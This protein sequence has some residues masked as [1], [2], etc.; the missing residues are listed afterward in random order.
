MVSSKDDV[1]DSW[2][3]PDTAD[4]TTDR[5]G[6]A[7][8][9]GD[10]GYNQTERLFKFYEGGQK[11]RINVYSPDMFQADPTGAT[12]NVVELQAWLDAGAANNVP[13]MIPMG[14]AY[15][16]E[17]RI[18]LNDGQ[19]IFGEGETSKILRTTRNNAEASDDTNHAGIF[20]Q[21]VSNLRLDN[22]SVE[23]NGGDGASQYLAKAGVQTYTHPHNVG[24]EP[25]VYNGPSDEIGNFT[26][27][28]G[29]NTV[30]L[31]NAVSVNVLTVN[32]ITTGTDTIEFTA[33]HDMGFGE[34]VAFESTGTLPGGVADDETIYFFVPTS[35]TEGQVYA[36]LEDILWGSPVD[37]TT[38]GTGT[39][40]VR[41][42]DVITIANGVR[43]VAGTGWT[44]EHSAVLLDGCSGSISNM[45]ISGLYYQGLQCFRCS[46]LRIDNIEFNGQ[47]NRSLYIYHN[48]T[49]V[50]VN[51]VNIDC[52]DINTQKNVCAYGTIIA[53]TSG[54]QM[55]S[56]NVSNVNIRGNLTQ[57]F[58]VD[59]D[60]WGVNISNLNIFDGGA[61][62]FYIQTT[63]NGT[64]RFVN[65][66]NLNVLFTNPNQGIAVYT[67][68]CE[69]CS[70]SN[71]KI[72]GS[73]EGLRSEDFLG[74]E[75]RR[76]SYS[77]IHATKCRSYSIN[78][79]GNED[80]EFVNLYADGENLT[81][82]IVIF[83]TGGSQNT[84]TGITGKNGGNTHCVR[85]SSEIDLSASNINSIAG[86]C[87]HALYCDGC[88]GSISG[89]QV[90]GGTSYALRV[91]SEG[92]GK[93]LVSGLLPNNG[94]FSNVRCDAATTANT[95][96]LVE[97]GAS[98]SNA[99]AA[100]V[101]DISALT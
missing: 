9:E 39:V 53:S 79:N 1:P 78:I 59:D 65:V 83:F 18:N 87:S 41:N 36:S 90:S 61:R 8:A 81:Q 44:N 80:C 64:P 14:H 37:L 4:F 60:L 45:K 6:N 13:C 89:G 7:L 23:L 86:S 75:T 69:D 51:N 20:A 30:T 95:V 67:R 46:N 54:G 10:I 12:D 34:W 42:G 99:G 48:T 63:G 29:G 93:F 74:T 43:N 28:P 73:L 55:R 96:L 32:S 66:N 97:H 27:N 35:A 92:A 2:T 21:N 100:V 49:N 40:T 62:G 84:V 31:T 50:D 98:L 91:A 58:A 16:A 88:T 82:D 26:T 85:F 19:F 5:S 52:R 38:A 68:G 101:K 33:N 76:C 77:N 57:S 22:F 17:T 94:G 25:F 15:Q 71:V 3:A 11:I 47:L 70:F 24:D 72:Y 56:I